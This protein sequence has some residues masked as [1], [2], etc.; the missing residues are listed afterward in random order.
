MMLRITAHVATALTTALRLT[1]VLLPAA[2]SV[3]P[4]SQPL[5]DALETQY[6]HLPLPLYMRVYIYLT[7]SPLSL[8][9][10]SPHHVVMLQGSF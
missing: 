10:N 4:H 3:L 9:T 1:T 7:T 8:H 6:V 5:N 2:A